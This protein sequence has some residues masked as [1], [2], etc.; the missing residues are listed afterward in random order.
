[1]EYLV[2]SVRE[3]VADTIRR[4][5]GDGCDVAH[6]DDRIQWFLDN[7]YQ[8]HRYL[9][10]CEL[11]RIAPGGS[12]SYTDFRAHC[13]NW[14]TAAI[15]V[16]STYGTLTPA[17][18]DYHRGYF[19][20]ATAPLRPVIVFGT[21]YDLYGAAADLLDERA[22][23]MSEDFDVSDVNRKYF[24]SQKQM[25]LTKQANIYRR[26]QWVTNLPLYRSDTAR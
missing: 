10:L 20:F 24:R 11:P 9:S 16:D 18:A 15:F 1:M 17:T 2:Q 3:M 13:K 25:M 22:A 7:H 21:V 8:E 4:A 12:V 23:L 6:L 5:E 26:N 19:T 14:G